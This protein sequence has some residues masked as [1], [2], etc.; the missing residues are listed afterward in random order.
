MVTSRNFGNFRY[1]AREAKSELLCSVLNIFQ[2][3]SLKTR[4]TF[5]TLTIFLI[6][7]GDKSEST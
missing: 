2:R 6:D 1:G 3:L 5:F 7:R 4:V